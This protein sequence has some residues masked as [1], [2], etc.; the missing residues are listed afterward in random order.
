MGAYAR[1]RA[2]DRITALAGRGDD[3]VTFWRESTEVLAG[4]VPHFW[5]PCW[6]T[7]DPASLLVTSH[8]QEGLSEF[9]AE[10]LVSEYYEED[11]HQLADVA[12][13]DRGISTLLRG[14]RR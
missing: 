10:F 1:E 7:L 6:Y 12:R 9:P 11:V 14:H 5:A 3:L 13:S 4:T 8:F 2:K